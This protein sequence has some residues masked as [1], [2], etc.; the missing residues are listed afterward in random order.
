MTSILTL[1]P[2]VSERLNNQ[3]LDK[4]LTL[5]HTQTN[6]PEIYY[7]VYS[8]YQSDYKGDYDFAIAV[9]QPTDNGYPAIEIEDL[10]L[11]EKFITDRDHIAQTWQHIWLRCQQGL[12]KR[13]YTVDFEKYYPDGKVEIYIAIMPFC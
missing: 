7:G 13:A 3:Q 6:L 4:L 11:Y 9:E 1:R 8:N 10:I 2:L 5:W 12:I